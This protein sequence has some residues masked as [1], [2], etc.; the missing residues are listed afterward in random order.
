MRVP[1]DVRKCVVF[2]GLEVLNE[3]KQPE[4]RFSGTG[5]MVG[6][7]ARKNENISFSY[8][9][10][11]KH[12]EVKL[13]GKRFAVRANTKDGGAEVFWF[14]DV[15]WFHHPDDASADIAVMS[16]VPPEVVDYRLWDIGDLMFDAAMEGAGVG[17]GTDVFVT[18]LFAKHS[19]TSK[20]LPIVRAGNIAMLPDE[21]VPTTNFGDM[22]V[23]LIEARSIGGLS[24][25]PVF[26]STD[27]RRVL[28]LGNIHGHWD[29]PPAAV[30]DAVDAQLLKSV[31]AGVAM[32]TP[33]VK[34]YETIFQ[35]ELVKIREEEERRIT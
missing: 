1:E 15:H 27:T 22:Q 26:V 5:F 23:Y 25:S 13:R 4:L 17:V 19:G 34:I 24:G 8:L 14:Q 21:R 12:V 6:V 20:N 18:G 30:S 33:A 35:E 11:A 29:L 2:L 3:H 28:L 31:N 10:T 9:V 32:V 7:R 16:W